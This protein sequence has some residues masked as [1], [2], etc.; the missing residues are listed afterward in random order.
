MGLTPESGF[1]VEV[2][3]LIRGYLGVAVVL[4]LDFGLLGLGQVLGG[5]THGQ[6]IGSERTVHQLLPLQDDLRVVVE[7]DLPYL[8]FVG[9]FEFFGYVILFDRESGCETV[10]ITDVGA[11]HELANNSHLPVDS[12]GGVG[13]GLC[14]RQVAYRRSLK[15][16][17][18]EVDKS[19]GHKHERDAE[20]GPR[21]HE[22]GSGG[23]G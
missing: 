6:V 15:S 12:R 11:L 5:A 20:L 8:A 22:C 19:A 23:R 7:E 17:E 3:G 21:A 14:D 2:V 18:S 9:D 13:E 16:G 10:G 1:L 4:R